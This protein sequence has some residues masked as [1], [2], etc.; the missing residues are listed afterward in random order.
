MGSHPYER[1]ARSRPCLCPRP[2]KA[3]G[4]RF[5]TRGYP[6]IG[7]CQS[8]EILALGVGSKRWQS[9]PGIKILYHGAADLEEECRSRH[10]FPVPGASLDSS[11]ML[12]TKWKTVGWGPWPSRLGPGTSQYTAPLFYPYSLP[13]PSPL[14]GAEKV[15]GLGVA[16]AESRGVHDI[17]SSSS[18]T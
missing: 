8:S 13:A 9:H 16:L 6:C 18:A 4:L 15:A 14:P 11:P 17:C 12:W 1:P 7:Q 2:S 5:S 10:V 3:E